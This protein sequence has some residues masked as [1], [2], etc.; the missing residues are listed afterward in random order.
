MIA[1]RKI[2]FVNVKKKMKR[3]PDLF[4]SMNIDKKQKILGF[5]SLVDA[6]TCKDYIKSYHCKYKCWP[7]QNSR[8]N[9]SA[10][11]I[12]PNDV[13]VVEKNHELFTQYCSKYNTTALVI[14]NI[15][16]SESNT[17]NFQAYDLPTHNEMNSNEF[18][19][20]YEKF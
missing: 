16:V 20:L 17:I 5:E 6:H 2:F 3:S 13:S 8:G 7:I 4:Y 10:T 11:N 19:V 1:P 9:S 15:D 14:V 18:E 12:V